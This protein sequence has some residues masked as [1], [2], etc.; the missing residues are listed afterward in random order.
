MATEEE[1]QQFILANK[2][3]SKEETRKRVEKA[4]FNSQCWARISRWICGGF[5]EKKSYNLQVAAQK[6]AI[7]LATS[8]ADWVVLV[9]QLRAPYRNL[10]FEKIL[11]FDLTI[12]GCLPVLHASNS[13]RLRSVGWYLEGR[14]KFERRRCRTSEFPPHLSG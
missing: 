1:L 11:E 14:R 9:E 13:E 3:L 4:P 10:A 12:P 6:R 2:G 7:E 8:L 5:R